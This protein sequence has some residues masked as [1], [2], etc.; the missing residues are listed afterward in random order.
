MLNFYSC[1]NSERDPQRRVSLCICI[2]GRRGFGKAQGN[3]TGLHFNPE[4]YQYARHEWARSA[5][6]NQKNYLSP[7]P[8]VITASGDEENY[9]TAKR[10]GA[11]DFLT[12]PLDFTLISGSNPFN[13]LLK[14]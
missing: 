3:G 11:D 6:R 2:L 4:R 9:N 8:V 5:G 12:K 10:L 1:N 13:N 14:Y 7:P